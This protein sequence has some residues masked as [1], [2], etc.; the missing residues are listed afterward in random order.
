MTKVTFDLMTIGRC[1]NQTDRLKLNCCC[2]GLNPMSLLT[3]NSE[4]RNSNRSERLNQLRELLSDGVI[5]SSEKEEIK[6][7]ISDAILDFR[8]QNPEVSELRQ[9]VQDS[10]D[11]VPTRADAQEAIASLRSIF[12]DGTVTPTEYNQIVDGFQAAV[13]N[14]GVTAFEAQ[15]IILQA[16]L[17]A[18]NSGKVPSGSDIIT[19]TNQNDFLYGLGG[20]DNLNG[21]SKNNGANQIDVLVG[22]YGADLFVLGNSRASFY[23]ASGANDYAL[24][25]DFDPTNGDKVQLS[26]TSANYT[27]GAIPA[28]VETLYPNLDGTAVFAGTQELIGILYGTQVTNFNS[29]FSFV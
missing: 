23:R 10:V 21:A 25:V 16:E 28:S 3:R 1:D 13:K 24:I 26:G 20:E 29:G 19:G 15:A 2:S 14:L 8:E 11:N 12:A 9:L 5:S 22:G 7:N 18:A 6:S 4:T 17:V 27:L